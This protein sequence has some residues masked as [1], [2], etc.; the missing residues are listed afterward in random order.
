MWLIHPCSGSLVAWCCIHARPLV[1]APHVCACPFTA[2]SQPRT[3][4]LGAVPH[5]LTVGSNGSSF[6]VVAFSGPLADS[7]LAG[8]FATGGAVLITRNNLPPSCA[9][10]TGI[11]SV[12]T[13]NP[14]GDL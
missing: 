10:S 13:F 12:C 11:P 9:S 2:G 1:A 5:V 7:M 14:W 6:T 4:P 3:R 8:S